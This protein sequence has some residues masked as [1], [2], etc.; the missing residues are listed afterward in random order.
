MPAMQQLF[1]VRRPVFYCDVTEDNN[2]SSSKASGGSLRV[3]EMFTKDVKKIQ[4]ENNLQFKLIERY[5]SAASSLW[6]GIFESIF[7]IG[8]VAITGD[9]YA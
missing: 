5:D 8:L 9:I 7:L 2:R 3:T 4:Q 1:T 6:L